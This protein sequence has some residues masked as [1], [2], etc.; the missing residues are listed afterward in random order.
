[1][2]CSLSLY[3]HLGVSFKCPLHVL[4]SGCPEQL[5]ALFLNRDWFL[6]KIYNL[7]LDITPT[8]PPKGFLDI[9]CPSVIFTVNSSMATGA[10]A[11]CFINAKACLFIKRQ[12]FKLLQTHFHINTV[13]VQAF[14]C[15][16]T[17]LILTLFLTAGSYCAV[18]FFLINSRLPSLA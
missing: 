11:S 4:L 15:F 14:V 17:W 6:H 18:L 16:R 5:W 3:C 13:C 7:P 9:V 10:V 12:N 8:S 2:L 1:M